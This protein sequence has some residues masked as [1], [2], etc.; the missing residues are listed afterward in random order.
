MSAVI[1]YAP[2]RVPGA[3]DMGHADSSVSNAP[4]SG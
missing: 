2:I 3:M 1:S 4:R